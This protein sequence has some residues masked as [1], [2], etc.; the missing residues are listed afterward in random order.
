VQLKQQVKLVR[1]TLTVARWAIT[2]RVTSLAR[3]GNQHQFKL[4]H[5]NR[6]FLEL[7]RSKQQCWA[8]LIIGQLDYAN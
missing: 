5:R 3:Y 1:Q 2:W 8:I 6:E 4:D 7:E